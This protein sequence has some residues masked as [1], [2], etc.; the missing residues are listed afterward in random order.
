M[1]ITTSGTSA[2]YTPP[3]TIFNATGTY[4]YAVSVTQTVSGC[5]STYSS[6]AQIVIVGDPTISSPTGANYCQNAGNVIQLSVSGSSGITSPYTFQWYINSV[7]NNTSGTVIPLAT[8]S[9]YTPPVSANGTNYYYCVLNQNPSNSGCTVTS[10]PAMITVTPAPTITTQPIATQSVCVGGTLSDLFVSYSGGTGTPTYQWFSNTLNAYA[11]GTALASAT[12]A[13][14]TPPAANTAGITYYYCQISFVGNSGCSQ[15]NSIISQITVVNDPVITA[16]PTATQAIC[17]GGIIPTPLSVLYN[18]GLG[19]VGYQWYSVSGS[20]N[21]LITGASGATYTPPVLST[22]GTYN[23]MVQIT[24]SGTG[25]NQI[26]STNAQIT[27]VADPMVTNPVG[28]SYCLN[29]STAVALNVL[30]S[31]GVV[32]P[33]SYQWYASNQNNNTTGNPISGAISNS[34]IPSATVI[35]TTYFYCVVSQGIGCSVSSAPAQIII[36]S[37][38]TFNAQ[39]ISSQTVCVDGS[40]NI[41][42]VGYTGGSGL[43]AYQWYSNSINSTVGGVAIGGATSQSYMPSTAI[44]GT[45]YYYC[46]ITFTLSGCSSITSNSA[47]ITVTPDP[48][49]TTQPLSTQTIC[50]GGSIP[51]ALSVTYSGGTGTLSYQWFSVNGS[52]NTQISGATAANYLPSVFATPGTYNYMVQISLSGSGCNMVQS[53]NAQIIALPD[54]TVTAPNSATYCNGYSP[55]QALS[56]TASGG[57]TAAYAYQWYSNLL[58]SNTSG[59]LIPGAISSTYTPS[60]ST[61][62]SVYYYCEVNQGALNTGCAVSSAT[63]LITTTPAPAI[64]AHPALIQ[65]AC[66]GG[67]LNN[68]TVSYTGANTSPSYQWFSNASNANTGGTPIPGANAASYLPQNSIAGTSYYYCVISFPSISCT[69]ISSNTGEVTIHPDPIISVQPLTNQAICFGTTLNTPL[70]ISYTGGYGTPS[71]Q[72]NLVNGSNNT[73]ITTATNPTYLPS[74]FNVAGTFNFNVTLSLS[75]NGCNVQTS[76]LAEV[77]VMPLPIVDNVGPYLYCNAEMTDMIV[78]S[79]PISGTTYIWSNDNTGIGLVQAGFGNIMPF[80]VTNLNNFGILGNITVTPQLTTLNTTC[81]GTPFDFVIMANPYQDVQDPANLVLCHGTG[82]NGVQFFGSALINNWTNDLPALGIPASGSG[83]LPA[84]LAVNNG[85]Q[86]IVANLSVTPSFNAVTTC[87]GDIETF[88]ITIL[89]NPNVSITPNTQVVCSGDLTATINLIGTATSFVWNNNQTSIGLTASG[90]GNIPAF[91]TTATGSNTIS[92]I[93]ATPIYTYA[94]LSCPGSVQNAQITVVPTPS[95]L[96]MQDLVLCNGEA[97]GLIQILGNANELSWTSSNP[98]IGT[99]AIGSGSITSFNVINPG[100]NPISS[101]ITVTPLNYFGG[102]TCMASS[103]DFSITVNPT[104]TMSPISDQVLCTQSNSPAVIFSGNANS[105]N[106]SNSNPAIGLGS[107]GSGNISSFVTQNNLASIATANISVTPAYTNAGLTCYGATDLFIFD[108]LP[109]PTV[110]PIPAQTVCNNFAT[111]PIT[112]TG[113]ATAYTWI[114]NNISIGLAANGVGNISGFNGQAAATN[115]ASN[116]VVTPTYVYNNT[117]CLGTPTTTTITVLPSPSINNVQDIVACNGDPSGII[118]FSGTAN[119]FN[120]TNSNPSIGLQ[121]NGSGNLPVFTNTNTSSNPLQATITVIPQ[122]GQG[123]QTCSGTPEIFTIT[124]NPT[125]SMLAPNN[126]ILCSQTQTL[127]VNFT[128]NASNYSWVNSN[129]GIGL[130][131]FGNGLIPAFIAQNNS[132]SNAIAQIQVTPQYINAGTTCVGGSQSFSI[133]IEPIPSIQYSQIAQAICTGSSTNVI[134]LSS[135]TSGVNFSWNILN[136]SGNISG[137]NSMNGIGN[138]PSMTLVNS[139]NGSTQFNFQGMATTPLASCVGYG[140]IG[141][142]TVDPAPIMQPLNDLTICSNSLVNYNLTASIPSTFTW[143]ASSNPNILGQPSNPVNSNLIYNTLQNNSPVLQNITYS[144]TPTSFPLGCIGLPEEFIAEVVPNIQITSV[145]DYEI[146]SGEPTNITLQSNL[147]GSF[148]FVANNNPNVQGET[149]NQQSGF[150]INDVLSNNS[151]YDQVVSYNIQVSSNPNACFGIPQVINV[152]VHPEITVTNNSPLEVCSGDPLNLTLT[153]TENATFSWYA[154]DN[155]IVTGETTISQ[156]TPILN[157]VLLNTSNTW[158]EVI[159]TVSATSSVT[160]CSAQSLPL[161]VN[162]NPIPVVSSLPDQLH[163]AGTSTDPLNW[164]LNGT[165]NNYA[166]INDNSNIGLALNGSGNIASFNLTN[167]G[168]QTVTSNIIVTPQ[169]I[170]NGFVC[171]GV[172]DQLSITVEPIPS[173]TYNLPSQAICSATNSQ[174]VTISSP[175]PG[176]TITWEILNPPL[177]ISGIPN[178]TGT[179]Q[180][181][182]MYLSSSSTSPQQMSFQGTVTTPLN[183]CTTVGPIGQIVVQPEPVINNINDLT[184]CN[185]GIVS[186]NITSNIP[187]TFSWGAQSNS[188]VNGESVGPVYSNLVYNTLQNSSSVIQYVYYTIIPTSITGNCVGVDQDFTVEVIPDIVIDP[189]LT[190]L[191]DSICSGES[192]GIYLQTNLPATL[193]WHANTNPNV[194]GETTTPTTGFYI[195]DVLVNNTPFNQYVNYSIDMISS[196]YGCFGIPE[197]ITMKVFPAIQLTNATNINLCSGDQLNANLAATVNATFSWS[198]TNNGVVQGESTTT[199]NTSLINDVLINN[200]ALSEQVFYAVDVQALTSNCQAY[201]LPIIV[202]VLPLP[203]VLNQDTTMCSGEYTNINLATNIPSNIVWNGVFNLGIQGETTAN[204]SGNYINDYLV[205][206]TGQDVTLI[207]EIQATANGCPAPLDSI[208]VIVH[209]QPTVDF[210]VNTNPLC[211]N[212]QAQFTNLS[213]TQYDFDWNFGD[214]GTS[215]SYSPNHIYTNSGNYEVMLVATNLL[216]NCSAA[217][218]AMVVVN[219]SPDANFNTLDTIGCGNLNATF[220]AN[221]QAT[222]DMVWDFGDGQTL[223]QV[224]NV[225]NYYGQAGCYDVTLT[226]TSPEGCVAQESYIDYVCVY[227]NPIAFIGASPMNVNALDPTVQFSNYSQNAISYIWQM[228]DG[229]ISYD[230]NPTYT[231]PMEG[232]DYHVLMTAFNEVGCFDT[233]SVD[234]HVYEELIFYVPNSFTPNDDEKNQTFYPVLSQGM[235]RN[236]LEF[237]VYNRWGELVF[238][239]HDPKYGWDGTYGQGVIDCPVGTYTWKLKL[240]T[241]QSQEIMEFRGHVNLIR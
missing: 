183:S 148:T 65:T 133:T 74:S 142:I 184:I 67:T 239:S 167:S 147:P 192:T 90:T 35:G 231:Y 31:A 143:T 4:N 23:Y 12:G 189:Q 187:A 75:G 113:N 209:D 131:S 206:N 180:I 89:P 70:N 219:K 15:I 37:A 116:I 144:V 6:N 60:V 150:Y 195:N 185:N 117:S 16:Q 122:T 163:C 160:G 126:Q 226:V 80:Q 229:N 38:P 84:F 227:E 145:L 76:N 32:G 27:V 96:P 98:V 22:I 152:Q 132:Q 51:N 64:S 164:T 235:K 111:A 198:A 186:A 10:N 146:C 155:A 223:T 218:S 61:N 8:G 102:L 172:P 208:L 204:I 176:V 153:A 100:Q 41:L 169:Y 85:T 178:L 34:Y 19:T 119:T 121:A 43:P 79:G 123:N 191:F 207:Y 42:S 217:D 158:H 52:T 20:T 28:T 170:H 44:A 129:T 220:F 36:T 108:V 29:S 159:Y 212:N 7:S 99:N 104:P 215:V 24:L 193:T 97:T 197:I 13:T 109:T 124:V 221:Y 49:V 86:P 110:N 87:P 91:M 63:A 54:P 11:G 224:G 154:T 236:Y 171:A 232:A 73:P 225:T 127:P 3:S 165:A 26:Q 48:V 156:N 228:G 53:N 138:I 181:P 205:N 55:V 149:S 93:S 134:N 56:V 62:G 200:S 107:N 118:S 238:E 78:F 213:P 101:V 88:T 201:D 33:Y 14:F 135:Q 66:V 81:S 151:S 50:G 136:P 106:W 83:T 216:N 114:N 241:L 182:S 82:V 69:T 157:D 210:V 140:P 57:L 59:S 130:S 68:L 188:N 240:E 174:A 162:V 71:Y 179:N 141:T 139:S 5:A 112:F 21:T 230:D 137:I 94:G 92:T 233:S 222:S 46:V 173:I 17:S 128:G 103:Q 166:W 190:S 18:Y 237:Y 47:Q 194:L 39:P 234:I 1:P 199:Q 125:P 211:T 214:G 40:L 177:A 95:V 115:N 202:N 120:W 45:N 203:L 30:A 105:F 72:W 168:P 175:N 77:I 9:S 161:S 196:P 2:T 25:C 58:N